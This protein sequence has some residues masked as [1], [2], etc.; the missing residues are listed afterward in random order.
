M[1]ILK[2]NAGNNTILGTA[3]VDSIYGFDG[4]DILKGNFGNDTLFGGNGD[5][6]LF[7]NAGNDILLGEA[8]NDRL[9]GGLGDDDLRGGLGDDSMLGGSGND[10]ISGA[11]GFDTLLGEGGN[12]LLAGGADSDSLVGGEGDDV[13]NG[14]NGDDFLIGGNGADRFLGGNGTDTVYYGDSATGVTAYLVSSTVG[15]GAT[16]DSF[17]A[18]ENVFGSNHDDFLQPGV[19]G[20][21]LGLGGN[22]TI[23]DASGSETLIGGAGIDHLRGDGAW[24]AGADRFGLENNNGFDFIHGFSDAQNDLL[25]ID[26]AA[27]NI[28]P[29]L[30]TSEI[31]NNTTGLATAGFAQFIYETDADL[32]WFD[33]N[34]TGAGG[35]V[36]VAEF[37]GTATF[38]DFLIAGDFVVV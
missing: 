15:G 3:L 2:G 19:G 25:Q 11:A 14:Q 9:S 23:F 6:Q 31:V 21:V 18:M 33:S 20:T 29:T 10:K 4:N 36:L 8:G 32:L 37:V 16:G 34:G 30:E 1:A 13:L 22:D 35:R 27:F 17:L 12:D 26:D 28:G 7:G 24:G 38:S 5:D